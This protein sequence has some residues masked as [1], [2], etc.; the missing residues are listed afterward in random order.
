MYVND[1]IRV[2]VGTRVGELTVESDTGQRKNGYTVWLCRCTCGGSVSLD[3]RTLRRGTVRD[4][5]CRTRVSPGCRDLTGQRFGRLVALDATGQRNSAGSVIWR[6]RCD[7]GGEIL[8]S[9]AQLTK[10]YTKSCG[11]LHRPPLKDYVGRRFGRLTVTAYSGKI[12]GMHRWEC[13]CDCGKITI[14]GQTPLQSGKTKSCGCLQAEMAQENM[15]FIN[16]TSVTRLEAVQTRLTATNTSGHNGVYHNQR[17]QKW[18][19]QIGF[20]GK[21]YYLG[22]YNSI[23]EAVKA[24]K[25]AEERVY[26]EFLDWYYDNYPQRKKAGC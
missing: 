17:T 5:G 15:R 16:G 3:T 23:D 6:C 8:T 24:R 19:A 13:R 20:Q 7:C 1:T 21:N 11:C 12:G 2:G 26:G 4:C 18:V 14:V 9:T 25:K 22:A 10:G